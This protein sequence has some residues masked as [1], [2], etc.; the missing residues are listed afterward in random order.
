MRAGP[1]QD[2]RES[3][4][5]GAEKRYN[6]LTGDDEGSGRNERLGGRHP[7]GAGIHGAD[8][9]GA[10]GRGGG[11]GAGARI[12]VSL[13]ANLQRA[14]RVYGWRICAQPP[15]DAG[16]AGAFRYGCKGDRRRAE[17]RLRFAG[18]LCTRVRAVSRNHPVG[19][20]RKGRAAP[21]L[22]PAE[23]QADAGGWKHAGVQNCEEACLYGDGTCAPV[24][25]GYELSR[26][27][28]IL[29][30]SHGCG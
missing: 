3:R 24:Q 8:A 28:E 16:R 6:S 17:I 25:H 9:D 18:Q 11:C 23:N 30:G 29:G 15:A 14:V 19:R 27:P 10:V 2:S 13:S 21:V 22:R 7:A 12:G 5:R 1:T 26:N 20:E 4:A